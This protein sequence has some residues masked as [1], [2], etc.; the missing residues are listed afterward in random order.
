MISLRLYRPILAVW[1]MCQGTMAQVA[2][3]QTNEGRFKIENGVRY[4]SLVLAT[5][6]AFIREECA[7]MCV[8]DESCSDF[9]FGHGRCELLSGADSCRTDAEGWSYGY[10]PTGKYQPVIKAISQ[11]TEKEISTL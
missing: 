6:S 2:S 3:V 7:I 4:G 10:Y 5:H 11:L 8:Q 9:N 1:Y